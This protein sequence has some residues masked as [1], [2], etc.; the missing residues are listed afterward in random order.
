MIIK[1][2]VTIEI[3]TDTLAKDFILCKPDPEATPEELEKHHQALAEDAERYI[4]EVSSAPYAIM[5]ALDFFN[6]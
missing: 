4:E 5:D 3:D 6:Y 1:R 2:T